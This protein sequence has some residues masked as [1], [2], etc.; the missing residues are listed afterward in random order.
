MGI[1]LGPEVVYYDY[2]PVAVPIAVPVVATSQ[3]MGTAVIENEITINI[4]IVPGV[5]S[6]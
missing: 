5:S 2:A 3:G 6:Q 1:D 4:T